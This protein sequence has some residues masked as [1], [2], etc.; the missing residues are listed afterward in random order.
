MNIAVPL[1][2]QWSGT[3][4]GS[5]FSGLSNCSVNI[6]PQ[7]FVVNVNPPAVPYASEMTDVVFVCVA[8]VV[9]YLCCHILSGS[10]TLFR[11]KPH[12]GG[13][14]YCPANLAAT[15]APLIA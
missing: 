15:V 3:V 14:E 9:T 2:Q 6:S 8:F 12:P 1:Q 13:Y 5:L 11:T 4:L 7:N 10:I